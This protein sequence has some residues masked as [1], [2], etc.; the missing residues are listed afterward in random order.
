M[1]LHGN[2]SSLDKKGHENHRNVVLKVLT[3]N[4]HIAG[5]GQ[6]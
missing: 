5:R 4:M 3:V 2:L 1:G 6:G